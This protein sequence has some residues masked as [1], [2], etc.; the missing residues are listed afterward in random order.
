[1]NKNTQTAAA[2]P[3]CSMKSWASSYT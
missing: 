1:M 2:D 3:R